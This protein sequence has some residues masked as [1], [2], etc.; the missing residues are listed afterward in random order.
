MALGETAL[1]Y[2]EALVGRTNE[3]MISWASIARD[4]R[5]V[6]G[7]ED[8]KTRLLEGITGRAS[9]GGVRLSRDARDRLGLPVAADM[10]SRVAT[11]ADA[12]D[13]AT[14]NSDFQD[15]HPN[16]SEAER[17]RLLQLR[18]RGAASDAGDLSPGGVDQP[19]F[20]PDA[21]LEGLERKH[22][23]PRG[24]LK[25]VWGRE[26]H[27]GDPRFMRSPAGAMGH[28][29]FMPGTA[30]EYG[31]KDPDDFME[32]GDAAARKWSDLLR[33]YGGNIRMAAAAYNWGD[34]NLAR[35]GLG[36]APKETRDY[37]DAVAGSVMV[38]ANPTIQI[39]GVTDPHEAADRVV[40]SQRTVN[41]DIVR[42]MS[43]K[44]R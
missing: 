12:V 29:G 21:Y 39:I 11:D 13:A 18:L 5:T 41:A 37:M 17:I 3:L 35:Y 20:D 44:V 24:L 7:R 16:M 25:R 26:S 31:L 6:G 9:G 34:G 38:Q 10:K 2:V 19:G 8:L 23:L 27:F 43:P 1:P 30:K 42:N 22:G 32:S 14:D 36:N 28:F 4:A 15:K 40:A 33:R